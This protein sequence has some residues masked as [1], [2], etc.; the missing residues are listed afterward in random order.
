MKKKVFGESLVRTLSSFHLQESRMLHQMKRPSDGAQCRQSF[1][2]FLLQ[3]FG[4]N[5]C[6]E[7]SGN[8]LVCVCVSFCCISNIYWGWCECHQ[9]CTNGH[10]TKCW[11]L[12]VA[13]RERSDDQQRDI[14]NIYNVVRHW[15]NNNGYSVW[16]WL[17]EQELSWSLLWTNHRHWKQHLCPL[18]D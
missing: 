6:V 3:Y 16:W 11:T 12:K 7:D 14:Y 8:I 10:K 17:K 13:P 1:I 2:V 4:G 9:F 15:E 5:F 18:Y